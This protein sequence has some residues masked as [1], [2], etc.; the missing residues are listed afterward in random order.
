METNTSFVARIRAIA[1]VV[2]LLSCGWAG[3]VAPPLSCPA[4]GGSPGLFPGGSG[5]GWGS[6]GPDASPIGG[7]SPEDFITDVLDAFPVEPPPPPCPPS[8][9]VAARASSEPASLSQAPPGQA[10]GNPVDLTTGNKYA[11]YVDV[12]LPDAE[13]GLA[14][15]LR[16][17]LG[18]DA[19]RVMEDAWQPFVPLKLMFSRHYNSRFKAA[20]PLG[21]GWRHAFE[22]ALAR[23]RGARG[24]ELQVVQ[25]DGRRLVFHEYSVA[26]LG[27]LYTSSEQTD[28]RLE[29]NLVAPLPWSWRWPDG[30]VLRFDHNGRLA[31]IETP[32]Q[33]RIAL[34]WDR[35]GR[36]QRVADRVGRTLW[37]H[38]SGERLST[39]V[40]PDGAQIEYRYDRH[41]VLE[42]VRYPDGRTVRH[43]Y[44]DL[45]AFHLLTGIEA[46]DRTRS[47]YAYDESLRGSQS[48]PG[49]SAGFP[50][51]S[52]S[53][54]LPDAAGGIGET[55]VREGEHVSVWRW[56]VDPATGVGRL[57][58]MS[59]RPCS[60]CPDLPGKVPSPADAAS[61]S[62]PKAATTTATATATAIATTAA[63]TTPTKATTATNTAT[64][65]A[66]R[67]ATQTA[68]RAETPPRP[69]SV[70]TTAS[71]SGAVVEARG[72]PPSS[73]L[74]FDAFGLPAEARITGMSIGLNGE[75]LPIAMHLRW[76]RHAEGPLAGKIAWVERVSPHGTAART[77]FFH[78]A[79][80]ALIAVEG[81]EGLVHRWER[82]E[83]G[84][85][86]GQIRADRRSFAARFDPH[87]RIIEWRAGRSVHK[88]EW[89]GSGRPSALEWPSGE[90]WK[91][92]W[93]SDTTRIESSRGWIAQGL[94]P[95]K[96]SS[97]EARKGLSV[98]LVVTD[99][100]PIV[101]DAAGR[102][103]DYRYDDFGRLVEEASSASG[104]RRYRYDE[105]GHIAESRSTDGHFEQRRYD[106]A[107]RLLERTLGDLHESVSTRFKWDAALLV[108]VE[109][110][111]QRTR[112]EYDEEGQLA[113]LEHGL[114][115][116]EHRIDYERDEAGRVVA[117]GLPGG[118]KL[119]YRFD[120]TGRPVALLL[121]SSSPGRLITILDRVAYRNGRA[122]SWRY[123]NGVRFERKDDGL[124]RPV[125]WH[126]RGREALPQWQ[127]RWSEDGLLDAIKEAGAEQR[128]AFDAF[129]RLIVHERHSRSS[130]SANGSKGDTDPETEYFAWDLAGDLRFARRVD[131][132]N[133]KLDDA[134][135]RDN[136]GRR[137]KHETLEMRYASHGRIA[138]VADAGYVKARYTYNAGGERVAKETSQGKTGFLYHGRELAAE[139]DGN[140]RVVRHYL[141]WY[142]NPV[143]VVDVDVMA[144]KPKITWLHFD[145]L[146]TPHAASDASGRKVWHAE[147][148]A[149][150]RISREHGKFRQP[151]RFAGQYYDPETGLHDN[152]L[153]S[154]DPATASYMEPDP[155]GLAGGLNRWSYVDGNPLLGTDPLGLILFAFDGTNNSNPAPK[156][157]GLS[158]VWKFFDH[159]DD[160]ARWYMAGVGRIDVGS[161][162]QSDMSDKIDLLDGHTARERV[163]YMFDRL[164]GYL[165]HAPAGE[166][167]DV[168]V[169][170]WSRGAAMAID[171][172]N[173]IEHL[174]REGYWQAR[175]FCINLRF[176]G[177]WETV[178]QFSND[179]RGW[180]L[181][182]PPAA[183]SVF[184]AVA[185][186][187]HRALFPVE[188][189]LGAH[190]VERG[191]I[192]SHADVG[193]SNGEGDLSDVALLW[194]VEMAKKTGITMSELAES[195]RIVE[196]PLLHDRN[197]NG[198]DRY[199]VRRNSAGERISN[200]PQK[201]ARINGMS[202]DE[203]LPFLEMYR[204]PRVDA[205]N[206]TSIAGEVN[207][208]KYAAW[209]KSNYGLTIETR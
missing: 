160:G 61:A 48:V 16:Q 68:T 130:L 201:L 42:A 134:P 205:A 172:V 79:R 197:Y 174:R 56:R 101:V 170:G 86:V 41:G 111:A 144:T 75:P 188:S 51:L 4:V 34:Y 72:S 6:I 112:A 179:S 98:G 191:F 31:Q 187:E 55:T 21:P 71:A 202:W 175:G 3:A 8:N 2:L 33:E 87:W 59:G 137:L 102:R 136:A 171:F 94:G 192:G 156:N 168:D 43:H 65:T 95:A 23:L 11:R 114:L 30:R 32:D 152:Y 76:H 39:L 50:S 196:S 93:K 99:P 7:V 18:A 85:A 1:L 29:E 66:A 208:V 69:G 127:Y 133:W 70:V 62:E 57:I 54:V 176:L 104:T 53:Y 109:H 49:P 52:F 182:V 184:H 96:A 145:H 44:E 12:E 195:H 164:M 35:N 203:T 89:N 15:A 204:A 67:T 123:G 161:G 139:T 180:K 63:R 166:T 115:G 143:A 37:L 154:Y 73:T 10:A 163:D 173:R 135:Q 83:L 5:S 117:R 209:L 27:R 185:L 189:G 178:A 158:N 19:E 97:E 122:V 92:E 148:E 88:I 36:L 17:A 38:Y 14:A 81:P 119:R 198:G 26:D 140:G 190:V 20:G 128:F 181:S 116:S 177:L 82:D 77:S 124:G 91:I 9:T 25:A 159:Y 47:H 103:T 28:G 149:F 183:R 132:S 108:G 194:M 105:W 58:S 110:P 126:W 40:L 199:V 141:R 107:G 165:D 142:G 60:N 151:L 90:R 78:D 186:N 120:E 118:G 193:G 150:G 131:G 146:G 45:R 167:I 113:A 13:S 129:G 157:D 147:Y 121:E 207:I 100:H 162:I 125:E 153:R 200:T 169:V 84:R 46:P 155:I 106:L 80:R 22:T 138:E 64:K 206:K 74:S 24:V